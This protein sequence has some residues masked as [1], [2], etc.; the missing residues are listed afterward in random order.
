MIG[1]T[2]NFSRMRFGYSRNRLWLICGHPRDFTLEHQGLNWLLFFGIFLYALSG[3]SNT[4]LGLSPTWELYIASALAAGMYYSVRVKRAF[5]KP[6]AIASFVALILVSLPA[7][8]TSDGIGG[9]IPLYLFSYFIIAMI[10][11]KGRLRKLAVGLIFLVFIILTMLQFAYPELA[12]PYPSTTVR[13]IDL[14]FSFSV[15]A[16]Y[17]IGNIAIL[18]YNL[19]QRRRLADELLVNI[20]PRSIAEELKYAPD[21]TI[22]QHVPEASVLFADVVNFTPLSAT[23]TA[24][25]LV[26]LLNEVFSH[27]DTLVEQRGLE[28]IKTIGDCYMVAAGVPSQRDDHS[29]V[30]ADLAL[31]MQ[32]Y[33]R[34]REFNGRKLAFRIGINSGPLV[35]GVI[36]HKKFIYDLWG[37]TVNIASRM[38]SHGVEGFIQITEATYNLIK[39]NFICEPRGAIDVKGKG[40]MNVWYVLEKKV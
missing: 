22:A 17:V 12:I 11:F 35:A 18:T 29:G 13:N 27:F 28:K 20:L 14:V 34:G 24:I 31:E 26:E 15:L 6:I 19:D 10:I 36:G 23:M 5:M 39:D 3:L 25:D 9:S 37:D 38:E 30:L 7:W 16:V 8:F 1:T 33:V 4:L 40:K 2:S 32:G 21:K